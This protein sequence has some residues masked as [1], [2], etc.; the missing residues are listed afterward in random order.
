MDF[1]WGNMILLN[2]HVIEV[3]FTQDVEIDQKVA[4]EILTG[5]MAL[6]EGEPHAL[7]Y[8]FGKNHVIFSDVA[9]K[10]SGVRNYNNANII[11]RAM[12]SQTMTSNMEI[13]FYIS[14]D[15]PQ[16]ETKFFDAKEKALTWLNQKVEAFL[17][18]T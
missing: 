1:S 8:D 4:I 17:H 5:I 16:A 9:R 15:K 14:H 7:L 6:S 13:S 10:I 12:V 11:S 2:K 3:L 18:T